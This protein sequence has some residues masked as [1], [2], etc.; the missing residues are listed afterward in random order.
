MQ[1]LVGRGELC[2]GL[3]L[4][5]KK[6]TTHCCCWC[7]CTPIALREGERFEVAD[8]QLGPVCSV[9]RLFKTGGRCAQALGNEA[10]RDIALVLSSFLK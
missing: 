4:K 9:S 10:S 1:E 3:F 7:W 6:N 2:G 8:R 5:K